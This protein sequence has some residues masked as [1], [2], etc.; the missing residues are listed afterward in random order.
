M[1]VYTKPYLDH[2]QKLGICSAERAKAE[3]VRVSGGDGVSLG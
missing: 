3:R 1:S 2:M